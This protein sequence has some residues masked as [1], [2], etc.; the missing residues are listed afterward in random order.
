MTQ[1][2]A[3]QSTASASN[4]LQAIDLLSRWLSDRTS[5]EN[6]T[7]LN[8]Q[9]EK[10]QK[11]N[12]NRDLHITLGLIPRKLSRSD[13]ALSDAELN[14]V[15]HCC[16][17]WNPATWSVDTAARILVLCHL[18]QSNPERFD[19]L[20]PDLF[21]SADLAESIAYY[22]G[23]AL[24]PVSENLQWQIGEGLRSNMRAVFESIAHNNPY[25]SLHFDQNRWNHM[26]LKALFI[27]STLA[28][29]YG[30]DQRAN[31]ELALILCDYAHERW[32][33]GRKVSPEL[34]RCVG[35]FASG[36][37]IDDLVRAASS[38]DVTEQRAGVLAL[39]QCP[40][41]KAQAHLK[42]FASVCAEINTGSL[43]WQSIN[44]AVPTA[45]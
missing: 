20:L 32:A 11:S 8:S 30:L 43:C 37:M 3:I 27:D 29:I 39:S 21:S 19:E 1:V 6:F 42:K 34:W 26:V 44:T 2:H 17:G 45:A 12:A 18:A 15:S 35:R 7:W 31:G 33:A 28:P 38:D 5:Q 14:Q 25:P 22:N 16:A 10:I 36:E 41:T 23:I 9:L 24:Y 4:A 13:L 40:D